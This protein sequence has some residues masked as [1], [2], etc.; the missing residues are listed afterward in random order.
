MLITT[1]SKLEGKVIKEYRGIVFGEVINGIDF[2]RDFTAN[3]TNFIGGRSGEY[4]EELV[5]TRADAITEMIKR[6]ENIGANAVIGVTFD[7]EFL[8]SK[9]SMVMITATG[10]AVV[11]E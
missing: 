3:I 4:E 7:Y 10:T 11:I 9:S 6:A 2:M 8:G 1:T 5:S